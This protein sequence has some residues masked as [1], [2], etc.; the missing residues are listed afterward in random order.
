MATAAPIATPMERLNGVTISGSQLQRA[1]ER[2]SSLPAHSRDKPPAQALALQALVTE[3]ALSEDYVSAALHARIAALAKW[4]AL[5]DPNRQSDAEAVIEAAARFPLSE[6]EDGVR[7]EPAGF[8]EM[9]LFI[10]ELPW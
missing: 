5:C 1:L 3:E 9:I 4:T 2:L 7:F 6:S 8:Q 10:E